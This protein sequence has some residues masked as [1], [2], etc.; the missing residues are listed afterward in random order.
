[1]RSG[2]V[3]A[4]ELIPLVLAVV[5]ACPNLRSF[6][7]LA[8][9]Y[10][11]ELDTGFRA[12]MKVLPKLTEIT[13]LATRV[14]RNCAVPEAVF[15]REISHENK[16]LDA[17]GEEDEEGEDDDEDADLDVDEGE[18]DCAIS[19]KTAVNAVISG[20]LG[21]DRLAMDDAGNITS[22][23]AAETVDTVELESKGDED[24]GRNKRLRR[25]SRRYNPRDFIRHWDED[26]SDVD[27]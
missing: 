21:D 16:T 25:K 13:Q 19:T 3:G 15:R 8:T 17:I 26:E 20:T 1:M 2:L 11:T 22:V 23:A 5:D 9:F 27:A 18:H 24:Q 10:S 7:W 14:P 12:L 6:F 4:E